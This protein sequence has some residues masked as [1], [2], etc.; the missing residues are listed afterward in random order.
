MTDVSEAVGTTP[1]GNAQATP[2]WRS[3]LADLVRSQS[4]V[5]WVLLIVGFP[6][7]RL[8]SESFPSTSL[9][10]NVLILGLFLS[11]VAFGQG[12]VVL[13]GGIDLSVASQV[14]LGAFATG[15]LASSGVPVVVAVLLALVFCAVVGAVNGI[16]VTRMGFPPF[17]V[18]L[19]VGT[20]L[21]SILLGVAQGAP[22]QASPQVLADL[23]DR[24]T[25]LLGVPVAIWIF[26][27]VAALC[28]FIQHRTTL[29]MRAYALGNSVAA[30]RNSRLDVHRA[31]T[32]VYS[33]AGIAYGLA[34]VM[35]LG[36]SSGADLNVG[37]SWLLPSIAAVVVGGSSIR[38]GSGSYGGTLAGALLLTLIGIDISAT[39]LAEGWK[40]VVYGLVIVIALV[41][42]RLAA[43]RR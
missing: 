23:M 19:A 5:V 43:R 34:G 30:A 41:G 25:T 3:R 26:V 12:L 22:A 31:T 11:V 9:L 27:V 21:A 33:V 1:A 32:S 29:G 2:A 36:Y 7:S 8:A 14:A 24:S 20:I 10:V 40:Q 17:I 6:L 18:T 39:G 13:T 38:G 15:S 4:F 28:L 16:L 35:L 42:A 37:E